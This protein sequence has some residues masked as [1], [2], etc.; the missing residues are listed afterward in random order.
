MIESLQNFVAAF[1]EPLQWLAVSLVSAIP[2][3]ESYFGSVIGVLMGLPPAIGILVAVLGNGISMLLFVNSA[4]AVRS[5]VRQGKDSKKPKYE[6]IRRAFDKFGIAGASLVG[7]SML[8]SQ[9]TSAA[10]V[11]FGAS[12]QKVIFW[13]VISIILWGVIFGVLAG[14]GMPLLTK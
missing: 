11:S 10:L 1:P 14:L 3:V 12:K 8:P 9:I 2:F 5:K 6:K 7:Q 4:H 13:Q